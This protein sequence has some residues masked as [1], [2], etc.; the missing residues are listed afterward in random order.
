VR[1]DGAARDAAELEEPENELRLRFG[2][3]VTL[4]AV[5][6]AEAL[7]VERNH[8]VR[9]RERGNDAGP[10]IE[11]RREAVHEN[12]GGLPVAARGLR[13]AWLALVRAGL[14][15]GSL[16]FRFRLAGVGVAD[17]D[18]VDVREPRVRGLAGHRSLVEREAADEEGDEEEEREQLARHGEILRISTACVNSAAVS[19]SLDVTVA[20]VP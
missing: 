5:G 16:G 8:T 14:R 20:M 13:D 4:G 7:Q 2:R 6:P 12:D 10:R 15:G 9:A 17:A 18:A 19:L 11:R 3:V 1:D